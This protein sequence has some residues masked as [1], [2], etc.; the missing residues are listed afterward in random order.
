MSRLQ[1]SEKFFTK[2]R[3]PLSL[4]IKKCGPILNAIDMLKHYM[5]GF[6]SLE[7]LDQAHLI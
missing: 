1:N 6:V 5:H 2:V 3:H 4:R 7:I